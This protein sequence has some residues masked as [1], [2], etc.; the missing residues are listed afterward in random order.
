MTVLKR[1]HFWT[2]V[3]AIAGFPTTA[4]ASLPVPYAVVGCILNGTFKSNGLTSNSLV[5]PAI[6]ALE[7]KTIRV[8][9]YLSPGDRFSAASVFI[10]DERCR[11]DFFKRYFLCA[12]CRTR[13][14]T[15]LS[16]HFR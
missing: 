9:G 13:P 3:L 8:E 1:R 14:G 16:P 15:Q 10:V 4:Q 12:P 11:E 5:D 6:K 7:G 2:A